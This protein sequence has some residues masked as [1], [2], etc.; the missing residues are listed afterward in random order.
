MSGIQNLPSPPRGWVLA[1]PLE[2]YS[3]LNKLSLFDLIG[4]SW[5]KVHFFLQ[6]C[7]NL[8]KPLKIDPRAYLVFHARD[9]DQAPS[10]PGSCYTIIDLTRWR[11]AIGTYRSMEDFLQNA[12][13][14]HVNNYIKAKKIFT[15][16]GCRIE[17]IQRDWS[18]HIEDVYALYANVAERHEEWLYDLHFFHAIA[19]LPNY[20]LLSAWHD[21]KMIAMT[22]VYEELSTLH[23]ICGGFDYHHSTKSYAYSWLNYALIEVAI[24]ANRYQSVDVGLT[25]NESKSNIGYQPIPSCMDVYCKGP[26][27]RTFL[28]LI[29]PLIATTISSDGKLKF[30]FVKKISH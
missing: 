22:V 20:Q 17:F 29:S 14:W 27:S 11:M 18:E 15:E 8:H 26:I 4:I 30:S 19:K 10:C 6:F 5:P 25:A 13:K 3:S 1:S 16:Y 21:D 12:K 7:F 23:S 28:R 24:N 2:G 9:V